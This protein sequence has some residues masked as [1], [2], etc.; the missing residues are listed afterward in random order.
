ML[1]GNHRRLSITTTYWSKRF[2][3]NIFDESSDCHKYFVICYRE[4]LQVPPTKKKNHCVLAKRQGMYPSK[5]SQLSSRLLSSLV[6][7]KKCLAFDI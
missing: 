5:T 1:V 2:S 4:G 6:L 3:K 7:R